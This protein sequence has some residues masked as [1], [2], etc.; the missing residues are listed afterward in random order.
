MEEKDIE[1]AIVAQALYKGIAGVV[2]TKDPGSLR[3]ELDEHFLALY[4]QTG[5]K[6]YELKV[7]GQKVGTASVTVKD[8]EY[9][10]Q[11]RENVA[12]MGAFRSWCIDNGLVK[13]EPDWAAVR[14]H[15]A[16]TGE[17]PDGMS[18][19]T[20]RVPVKS[21]VR[22]VTLRVDVAKVEGALGSRLAPAVA[23]L[24]GGAE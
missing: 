1:R 21:P 2:S 7:A 11:Q 19:E 22:R 3:H 16:V 13:T 4:E 6:S 15:M 5:G 24:L 23:G 17:V 10:E 9:E 12:D 8:G 18:V 14:R 20:V